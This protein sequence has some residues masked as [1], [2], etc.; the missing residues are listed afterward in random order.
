MHATVHAWQPTHFL[1]SI[2]MSHRRLSIGFAMARRSSFCI[3]IRIS[4]LPSVPPLLNCGI[5][6]AVP[7]PSGT[8]G[9]GITLETMV[10]IVPMPTAAP[11]SMIARFLST[12]VKEYASFWGNAFFSVCSTGKSPWWCVVFFFDI[13]IPLLVLFILSPKR[14]VEIFQ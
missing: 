13:G 9:T 10:E 5:C 2:T 11:I 14:I 3:R 1:V 4:A 12:G 8:D 6:R 7:L